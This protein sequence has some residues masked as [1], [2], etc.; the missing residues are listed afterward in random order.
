M[1]LFSGR[2]NGGKPLDLKISISTPIFH[3]NDVFL[4][5]VDF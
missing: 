2:I 1:S 3:K 4:E 5:G